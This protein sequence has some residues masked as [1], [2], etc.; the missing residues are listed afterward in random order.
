MLTFERP[1]D[2]A[3]LMLLLEIVERA[4]IVRDHAEKRGASPELFDAID[5]LGDA[6]NAMEGDF[7]DAKPGKHACP[8]REEWEADRADDLL[9]E[10]V[11]P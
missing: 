5:D 9:N 7:D 4:I 2:Y 10:G 1:P 8:S 11:R 3:T 6:V